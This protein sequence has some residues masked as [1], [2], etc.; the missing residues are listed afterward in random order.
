MKKFLLAGLILALSATA[1]GAG[2]TR[3]DDLNA[4]A[5]TSLTVKAKYVKPISVGLNY[6]EI[7]FGDVYTDSDV[8]AK[9]VTATITGTTGE[10]FTYTI[11]ADG[12]NVLLGDETTTTPTIKDDL[13]AEGAKL[14]DIKFNVGLDTANLTADTDVSEIVT[15]TV[16]YDAIDDTTTTEDG[17]GTVT[18]LYVATTD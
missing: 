12:S 8:T 11:S 14:G 13:S 9:L 3:S 18:A 7:D 17:T 5:E 4:S 6:S 10:T 16:Q 2:S 1:M 15:I